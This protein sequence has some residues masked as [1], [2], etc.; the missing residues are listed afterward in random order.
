MSNHPPHD[1]RQLRKV[2]ILVASLDDRWA[3]RILAN[4]APREAALVRSTAE[5]L[6]PV[7]PEE[8]RDVVEQFRRSV[9]RPTSRQSDGVELD[10]SLLAR[11]EQ[12][13]TVASSSRSVSPQRSFVALTDTDASTIVDMLAQEHPQTIAIVLSRLDNDTAAEVLSAMPTAQQADLLARLADLNPADQQTIAV[14]ESQLA[15]W[16]DQHRQ[17][18]QRMADGMNLVQ[19]ILQRTPKRQQETILLHLEHRHPALAKHFLQAAKH[20]AVA[21][22]TNQSWSHADQA[23]ALRDEPSLPRPAIDVESDKSGHLQRSPPVPAQPR[24]RPGRP[25]SSNPLAELE[26]VEDAVLLAAISQ[27]DRQVVSLALAGA[28]EGLMKRILRRLPRRQAKYFRRQLRAIGPTRLSD[29]LA[30]QQ[31]FVQSVHQLAERT[32]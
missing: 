8:Q 27:A 7:D 29:M 21:K 12:P 24:D 22:P 23:T 2:A 28:S 31:E 15:R 16:I 30:A 9:R 18:Q 25:P 5:Q 11:M 4:L 17:R 19:R 10:A 13:E 32:E 6:G 1:R 14:V 26:Q 3:Q 20:N